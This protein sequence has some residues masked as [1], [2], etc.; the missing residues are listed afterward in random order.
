MGTIAAPRRI[1]R[2]VTGARPAAAARADGGAWPHTGRL[3][4]WTLALFLVMVWLVPFDAI[5]L[6]IPMPLD[7]RLDR[8]MLLLLLGVW[9]VA[10][11]MANPLM[12]PRI[13]ISRIHVALGLFMAVAIIGAAINLPVLTNLGEFNLVLKKL[14]LL[15]SVALLFVIVAS[16]VRPEE[17]A[18]Y[19]TFSLGLGCIAAIGTIIEYR[20]KQDIFFNMFK[21]VPGL[22]VN[23]P[24][25][26]DQPDSIGRQTVYSSTGHP[27]EIATLL[28][29][30]VPFAFV[31]FSEARENWP[32]VGY[33]IVAG[34][35]LA[36]AISTFRKTSLVA[37]TAGI[38]V[39]L[40]YRPKVMLTR[41]APLAVAL[42]L[43]IHVLSPGAAGSVLNSLSPSTT[44]QTNTTMDRA[45]DYAATWPDISSHL[46][47]GRGYQSY[48]P[49][50]YRILD[51]EYL[52]LVIT[53]GFVGLAAWMIVLVSAVSV[54]HPIIRS[55]HPEWSSSALACAASVAVLGMALALFD[56][57]SFPHVPYLLFFICGMLAVLSR[58]SAQER[59]R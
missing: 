28:G 40:A 45:N 41:L 3:L 4:P 35:L 24:P 9:L 30:M 11:G 36:G 16:T 59:K 22:T 52:G 2:T 54:A 43:M 44:A 27:L 32:R 20:T 7:A 10:A 26:L 33:A 38:V 19:I 18:R 37:P 6:P 21:H 46:A 39:L 53:T 31:R 12:R 1:A 14:V 15:I 42:F 55:R 34:L 47:F 50:K 48:D 17:V 5:E 23:V 57:L 58:A 51:N 13:A 29:M 25:D 8:P 56:G 49:H